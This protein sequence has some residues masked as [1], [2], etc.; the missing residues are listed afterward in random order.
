MYLYTYIY[1]S[2]SSSSS[3]VCHFLH[4]RSECFCVE[5]NDHINPNLEFWL[6]SLQSLQLCASPVT[7]APAKSESSGSH[8]HCRFSS[9]HWR[10][11]HPGDIV[12]FFFLLIRIDV[13]VLLLVYFLVQLAFCIVIF[14]LFIQLFVW[15]YLK[16]LFKNRSGVN[17]EVNHL[18]LDLFIIL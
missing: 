6:S 7:C 16:L 13:H 4:F 3:C 11:Y 15:K 14:Y 18:V 2:S 5:N 17:D 1:I 12:S 10:Q 8:I 9:N